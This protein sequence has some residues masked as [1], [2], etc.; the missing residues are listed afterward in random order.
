MRGNAAD[1]R[2]MV[3]SDLMVKRAREL[4]SSCRLIELKV[5]A[6][7]DGLM[8]EWVDYILYINNFL[9]LAACSLHSLHSLQ[10]A[11]RRRHPADRSLTHP[12][13]AAPT[14]SQLT[15]SSIIMM[16]QHASSIRV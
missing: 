10:L 1:E 16:Q 8:I 2:E 3:E 14:H 5:D 7:W 13:C 15:R 9:Q 4:Q 6:S 12:L 11:G